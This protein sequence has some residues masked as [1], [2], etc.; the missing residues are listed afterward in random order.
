MARCKRLMF[1]SD[2]STSHQLVT[3]E[4]ENQSFNNSFSCT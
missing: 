2:V 3:G 4:S 1:T